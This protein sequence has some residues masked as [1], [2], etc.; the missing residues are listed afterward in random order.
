MSAKWIKY[1]G[2]MMCLLSQTLLCEFSHILNIAKAMD[3]VSETIYLVCR[4]A[5]LLDM[6]HNSFGALS[7]RYWYIEGPDHKVSGAP[8]VGSEKGWTTIRNIFVDLC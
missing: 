4:L 7:F 6:L 5:F 8:Y 2:S 1:E 3:L